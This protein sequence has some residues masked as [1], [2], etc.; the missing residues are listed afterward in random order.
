[1]SLDIDIIKQKISFLKEGLD[2]LLPSIVLEEDTEENKNALRQLI[3]IIKTK[4]NAVK[5]LDGLR[6]IYCG[7][8]TYNFIDNV[9]NQI[10]IDPNSVLIIGTNID[11][12]L[13]EKD[14]TANEDLP[15]NIG[16]HLFFKSVTPMGN[17]MSNASILNYQWDDTL[18]SNRYEEFS[19]TN[20]GTYISENDRLYH[21]EIGR[22]ISQDGENN[23]IINNFLNLEIAKVFDL[24]INT[25][26]SGLIVP[27]K[28]RWNISTNFSEFWK[29][30]FD[31]SGT[32][33]L[34]LDGT[35]FIT[36]KWVNGI[37]TITT[38]NN[39]GNLS[40]SQVERTLTLEYTGDERLKSQMFFL[41]KY[42]RY[43]PN[44]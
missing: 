3:D 33:K 9:S 1:M 28:Q 39:T 35:D 11:S 2:D 5:T 14:P 22:N 36:V 41:T 30:G 12:L 32:V 16:A 6:K 27:P 10:Y 40:E 24:H 18:P 8:L 34:K 26:S 7:E 21:L 17:A 31:G 20:T 15:I 38:E 43:Y 13:A 29:E 42:E 37:Q 23:G 19:F 4:E 44:V 25:A